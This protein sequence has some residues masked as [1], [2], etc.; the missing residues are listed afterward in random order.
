MDI[1]L[2]GKPV[3]LSSAYVRENYGNVERG[4]DGEQQQQLGDQQ[5]VFLRAVEHL[6][7]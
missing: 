6:R 4:L 2:D 1:C 7:S 3:A 5:H